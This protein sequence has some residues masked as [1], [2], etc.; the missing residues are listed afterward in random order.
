MISLGIAF[1]PRTCLATTKVRCPDR[2]GAAVLHAKTA[3]DTGAT[4]YPS[5]S[6]GYILSIAGGLAT[7]S[8]DGCSSPGPYVKPL[9]SAEA[10]ADQYG[11]PDWYTGPVMP[12]ETRG[13]PARVLLLIGILHAGFPFKADFV[14]RSSSLID[15]DIGCSMLIPQLIP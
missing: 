4:R 12:R 13:K 8:A 5:G 3:S 14:D 7:Y 11:W 1:A 15:S 2:Y 10:T 9:C 6:L